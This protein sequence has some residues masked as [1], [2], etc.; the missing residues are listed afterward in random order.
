MPV[1]LVYA[2]WVV[3]ITSEVIENGAVAI[4]YD[5][6]VV[7]LGSQHQMRAAFPS[8]PQRQV[9]GAL[10]PG[11][12]NAHVHVELSALR[13]TVPGGEGLVPWV[14]TMM[15]AARAIAD[16]RS[17]QAMRAAAQELWDAGTAAVGDVGNGLQSVAALGAVP[18]QGTFF[19]ELLGS[20]DG[21]TGDALAAANEEHRALAGA[22]GWPGRFRYVQAPHA[23]YSASPSLLQRIFKATQRSGERTTIHVAEDQDE[24]DLLLRGVG[25][26][27]GVLAAMGVP[28]GQRTPGCS[29][30]AYLALQ[31]AFDGGKPPVLVHMTCADETDIALAADAQA[32]V[33]LCPRSNLHITGRLPNVPAL[34]RAGVRL[35]L[36]TDSL[37]SNASLSLW[38][39]MAALTKHFP[40]IDPAVWL[41]AATDGGAFAL[42]RPTL[43]SIAPGK[44]PGLLAVKLQ[45][46]TANLMTALTLTT[47]QNVTWVAKP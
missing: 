4:D 8:A 12:V 21:A 6:V 39:E 46:S 47:R 25:R 10:L 3:P 36:G 22:G 31:G 38:E 5:G 24:I 13:D 30:V 17:R 28:A 18:L 45:T 1:T 37:A 43:G 9:E 14:Q 7:A 42:D 26:W 41:R 15:P 29:P 34:I 40:E 27:P 2:N 23:P 35:A 16:S 19:H 44:K 32:P 11:L 33:A 20:R